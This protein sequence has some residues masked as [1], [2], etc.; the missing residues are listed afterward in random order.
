MTN[1]AHKIFGEMG[2]FH[3]NENKPVP[4]YFTVASLEDLFEYNPDGAENYNLDFNEKFIEFVV[5]NNLYCRNVG[6]DWK[7]RNI[8]D[9]K[10]P[11]K[12]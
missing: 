1:Y 12:R 4:A 7:S 9:V 10:N 3:E 5:D 11:Q 8:N 6:I 2:F